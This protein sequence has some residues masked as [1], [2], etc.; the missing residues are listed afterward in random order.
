MKVKTTVLLAMFVLVAT[1]AWAGTE[2]VLWNFGSTS[3][4]GALPS[5]NDLATDGAGNFYGAT[6]RGGTYGF[7]A[8]FKLSPN[9]QGGYNESILYEFSGNGD[10]SYPSGGLVFDKQ[11][12][13]YG[14]TQ[15]GGSDGCDQGCAIVFELSP[16]GSSWTET[17]IYDFGATGSAP[18]S[19]GV[20]FDSQGNLYGTT[21]VGG[22]YGYGT[23][24]ELSPTGGAWTE[25]IIHS[26]DSVDGASPL[27]PVI[28]DAAGNLFGTT[29]FG[30]A[31]G[32]GTVFELS[33]TAAGWQQKVLHSFGGTHAD[34]IIPD[35]VKLISDQSGNIY[36]TT[37]LTQSAGTGTVWELVYSPATKN[38]SYEI[39]HTFHLPE[40][41]SLAYGGV[42]IDRLGNLYGVA[43]EGGAH[44]CGI[45]YRLTKSGS[46][47]SYGIDYSFAGGT[48]GA[49]PT[50][51]LLIVNQHIYGM[52][53]GGAY[54]SGVVFE[55]TP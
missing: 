10:G 1:G 55:V 29:A 13:L 39:L 8:V 12:N 38:Y 35:G 54:G 33:R 48:D 49:F 50:G 11:G 47:W 46:G 32:W 42:T 3:V 24:F 4:D 40:D 23:V 21:V 5:F 31:H 26:F 6:N 52:A 2:T 34:G 44:A 22:A 43:A 19:S 41:G 25:T 15:F 36:G 16:N 17:I 37:Y 18:V 53:D 14:T 9:G 45:V 30:G 7:G 51:N 27:S 28:I 20:V